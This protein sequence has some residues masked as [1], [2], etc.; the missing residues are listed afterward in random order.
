MKD[1]KYIEFILGLRK[2]RQLHPVV[3]KR[4][5]YIL[6]KI[7]PELHPFKE[8]QGL[9]G[10]RN[11]VLA[12]EYNGRK[13]L[14]EIFGSKSQ[15]SRDLRI[16]DK[17]DA[18]VKIAI[19]MDKEAD[20]S[21]FN[22]F[23]RENPEDAY[24]FIFIRE[25]FDNDLVNKCALKLLKLIQSEDQ[26]VF[27]EILDGK[28]SFRKFKELCEN[29]DLPLVDLENV[30]L[31]EVT[32]E[33]LFNHLILSKLFK[34]NKNYSFEKLV[35]WL[36]N[37]DVMEYALI[38]IRHGFN[39]FLYTDL[40][41]NFGIYSDIE[42][43]DFLRIGSELDSARIILSINSIVDTILEASKTEEKTG[44]NFV[45]GSSFAIKSGENCQVTVSLPK[46]TSQIFIN[47]PLFIDNPEKKAFTDE[48]VLKMITIV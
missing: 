3:E 13:V 2:K 1:E 43:V 17:T 6:S 21:V 23:I 42:L 18:D 30:K 4:L 33:Q 8:I 38:Q 9:A 28:Y 11:D 32:F 41:E 25:L 24:H 15:V 48:E 45:I 16:L 29:E 22:Q 37:K 47:K 5:M 44:I 20:E 36:S 12:Y 7:S 40:N 27:N 35:K 14:F 31:E 26:I 46:C 39:I 19:I 10:G 34:L